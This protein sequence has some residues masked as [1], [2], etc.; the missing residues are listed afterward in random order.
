MSKNKTWTG[1]WLERQLIVSEAF[2]ALKTPA[3]YVMLMI[4]MSKRQMEKVKLGKRKGWVIKNNGQIE[5]TYREAMQKYDIS[6]NKFTKALDELLDKGFIDIAAHGMGVNKVTTLYSVSDRWKNY[7]TPDF[8]K[9]ERP[10]GTINRGFQK[11]NRYGRNCPKD[12]AKTNP[13]VNK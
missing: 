8:V 12:D 5:F 13:T 9:N 7:G 11:G 4:F 1:I 10:K 3:S 6:D 2:R